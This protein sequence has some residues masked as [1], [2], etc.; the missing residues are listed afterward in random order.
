MGTDFYC[1]FFDALVVFERAVGA[2]FDH[3]TRFE[4]ELVQRAP[5]FQELL[6]IRRIHISRLE[7]MRTFD[8]IRASQRGEPRLRTQRTHHVTGSVRFRRTDR[9][10]AGARKL[11]RRRIDHSAIW[12]HVDDFCFRVATRGIRRHFGRGENRRRVHWIVGLTPFC[13]LTRAH[14]VRR[15]AATD[16]YFVADRRGCSWRFGD[17]SRSTD[18]LEPV[19]SF[20]C[21]VEVF[22]RPRFFTWWSYFL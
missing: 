5:G 10:T 6:P 22:K 4:A 12:I 21:V 2:R 13:D 15:T 18:A 3:R 1:G 19:P 7:L 20:K 9:R 17:K 16:R 14:L 8:R 11:R